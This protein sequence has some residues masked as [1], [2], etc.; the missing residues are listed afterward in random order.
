[1]SGRDPAG[2]HEAF[3]LGP[4]F[5]SGRGFAHRTPKMGTPNEMC[6]GR[7]RL[8]LSHCALSPSPWLAE[9]QEIIS[10]SLLRTSKP[11]STSSC[12]GKP[13]SVCNDVSV[14]TRQSRQIRRLFNIHSEAG[15]LQ[16]VALVR[17]ATL[18]QSSTRRGVR[19]GCRDD[20]VLGRSRTLTMAVP[21]C[22]YQ[23]VATR[24]SRTRVWMSMTCGWPPRASSDSSRARSS[25]KFQTVGAPTG[26]SSRARSTR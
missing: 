18:D 23:A 8:G 21:G 7:L 26:G 6:I 25:P 19:N 20:D 17:S 14:L 13:Y 15:A 1:M 24:P 11:L 4:F 16:R 10:V 2:G 9:T 3:V 22:P 12:R 5:A